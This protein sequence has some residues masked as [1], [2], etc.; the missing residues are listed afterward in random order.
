MKGE[1]DIIAGED[2]P[3]RPP[4]FSRNVAFGVGDL[5][6]GAHYQSSRLHQGVGTRVQRS[7][8][9]RRN[10]FSEHVDAGIEVCISGGQ[11]RE[12]LDDLI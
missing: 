8:Y 12:K 3:L 7:G 11:R 9:G 2:D 4:I 5:R 6:G 10:G 1:S